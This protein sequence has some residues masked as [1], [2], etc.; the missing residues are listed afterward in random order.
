MGLVVDGGAVVTGD[1]SVDGDFVVGT[2]SIAGSFVIDSSGTLTAGNI[3]W[4]RLSGLP[5]SCPSGEYVSGIGGTLT[6]SA[7]A[8]T[9]GGGGG[10]LVYTGDGVFV[11]PPGVTEVY[12]TAVGGGGGGGSIDGASPNGVDGGA[13]S[14]G[15]FVV[16]NGGRGGERGG[17]GAIGAGGAAGGAGGTAGGAGGTTS[18]P[19]DD[20]NL[21]C[22]PSFGAGG[23]TLLS[24]GG[25]GGSSGA[26]ATRSGGGGAGMNASG[27]STLCGYGGGGG[28]GDGKSNILVTVIP[29]NTITVTV[30]KKG[31][32]P[33]VSG[34][35]TAGGV[36]A[37]G[38]VQV[39]W[40]GGSG[41][42]GGGSVVAS[43]LYGWCEMID[44]GGGFR[45]M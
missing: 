8:G 1:L 16:A 17:I 40:F 44:G 21:Y 36:G 41:G 14:F 27:G 20:S 39:T 32:K 45:W 19:D 37:D 7:P 12:V 3:P 35:L 38:Y 28:G 5:S 6:C 25:G 2:A 9:E 31:N 30:G 4:A 23:Y 33:A 22:T 24:G 15:S 43:G 34:R 42:G 11:V 13:S 29:G 26:D 10:S 18:V